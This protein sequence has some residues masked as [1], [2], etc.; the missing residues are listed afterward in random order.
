MPAQ[1]PCLPAVPAFAFHTVRLQ[2]VSLDESN[3]E[4]VGDELYR[5]AEERSSA[6]LLLD[7][8]KVDYLNSTALAKLVGLHRRLS[9]SGRRL[10]LENVA[11]H[12][13]DVFYAT[14]L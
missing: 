3:A 14:R 2:N 11:P 10:A 12:V 13:Y 7:F 1:D 8:G 5:V 4:A 6:H 9:A